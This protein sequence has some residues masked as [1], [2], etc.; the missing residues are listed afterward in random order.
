MGIRDNDDAS[1]PAPTRVVREQP[2]PDACYEINGS[3]SCGAVDLAH[4]RIEI[5]PT[6]LACPNCP[7]LAHGDQLKRLAAEAKRAQGPTEA[8]HGSSLSLQVPA[9]FLIARSA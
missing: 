5:T 7:R 3:I 8:L 1:A 9:D 6:L 4:R 2:I